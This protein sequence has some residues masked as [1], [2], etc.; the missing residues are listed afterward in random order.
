MLLFKFSPLSA[1][2]E[3]ISLQ[4]LSPGAFYCISQIDNV[5]LRTFDL[6]QMVKALCQNEP[7]FLISGYIYDFLILPER[8]ELF[9]YRYSIKLT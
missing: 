9:R 4:I 8:K 7:T 1:L 6:S 3:C 2:L 5:V